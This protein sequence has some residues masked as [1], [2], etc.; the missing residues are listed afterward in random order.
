LVIVGFRLVEEGIVVV[1]DLLPP[2]QLLTVD[3]VDG[4][5]G[6]GGAREGGGEIMVAVLVCFEASDVAA[7][8]DFER[9]LLVHVMDELTG[10][11]TTSFDFVV[12]VGCGCVWVAANVVNSKAVVKSAFECAAAAATATTTFFVVGA[13]VTIVADTVADDA[14]VGRS[15][16]F[17][18][19]TD[20]VMR[21]LDETAAAAAAA[22][23]ALTLAVDVGV[24]VGFCCVVFVVGGVLNLIDRPPPEL[25]FFGGTLIG[26]VPILFNFTV[27]S[28]AIAI[29]TVENSLFG[30]IKVFFWSCGSFFFFPLMITGNTSVVIVSFGFTVDFSC[31]G[32]TTDFA[33]T[34][35]AAAA[36]FAFLIAFNSFLERDGVDC[37][38]PPPLPLPLPPPPLLLSIPVFI[39]VADAVS[40]TVANTEDALRFLV[41]LLIICDCCCCCGCITIRLGTKYLEML[42]N[43]SFDSG[44][45]LSVLCADDVD[46][47]VVAVIIEFVKLC[48]SCSFF[49]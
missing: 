38:P 4:G 12:V 49:G 43:P 9:W 41:V 27:G 21:F 13:A 10:F 24:G 3:V 15:L 36:F 46:V 17:S 33:A 48:G 35:T 26:I 44:E 34:A 39:L 7:N 22:V 29:A 14:T 19:T 2:I 32:A 11:T 16:F 1:F 28:I 45:S 25:D 23:A 30:D 5:G 31:P 18:V 42:G 6:G 40:D 20:G 37:E 8:V 47:V